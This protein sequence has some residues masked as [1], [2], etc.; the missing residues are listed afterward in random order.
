MVLPVGPDA[1]RGDVHQ[2]LDSDVN[3]A[4]FWFLVVLYRRSVAT[5]FRVDHVHWRLC[6]C[7]V[8][9]RHEDH[10]GGKESLNDGIY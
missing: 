10:A 3:K 4:R 9:V 1:G 7:V 5:I 6:C 8:L 2:V